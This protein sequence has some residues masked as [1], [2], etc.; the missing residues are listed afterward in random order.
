MYVGLRGEQPGHGHGG[1][2]VVGVVDGLVKWPLAAHCD[3]VCA[4]DFE[5]G[6]EGAGPHL[7]AAA[8]VTDRLG[9]EPSHELSRAFMK[10][11][12]AR[13]ESEFELRASVV[14]SWLDA[15]T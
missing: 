6:Y 15:R 4:R 1:P 13:L 2:T 3:A 14:D 10:D 7:L 8:I 5:W 12:V 9:R 11:V